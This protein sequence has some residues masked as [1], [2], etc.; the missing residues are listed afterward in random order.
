[1]CSRWEY[2]N[3]TRRQ[4][5]KY[6]LDVCF[7][8]QFATRSTKVPP[9]QRARPPRLWYPS[10]MLARLRGAR[11]TAQGRSGRFSR[12]EASCRPPTARGPCA[13]TLTPT[14]GASTA[15]H[16]PNSTS[17]FLARRGVETGSCL[18]AYRLASSKRRT[19]EREK[20]NKNTEEKEKG[21]KTRKK[22][23]R[24]KFTRSCWL[25]LF[26]SLQEARSGRLPKGALL[27]PGLAEP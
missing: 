19:F 12:C 4:L 23:T 25:R 24:K 16:H 9:R 22:V 8:F 3:A 18:L 1:M 20:G 21:K 27:D 6:I 17:L 26:P 7:A 11:L 13:N 15:P 5:Y 14:P 2:K 10:Q